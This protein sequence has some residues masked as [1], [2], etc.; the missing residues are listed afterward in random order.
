MSEIVKTGI[1]IVRSQGHF[2]IGK[3]PADVHL[4]GY[5]EFPGGKCE[6]NETPADCAT[7]E[8]QEETGISV[9][10][11]RLLLETQHTY[12]EKTVRLNFFLCAPV[13]PGLPSA[14]GN[15][16]WIPGNQLSQ[17]NFPDGNADVLNLLLQLPT[18]NTNP[19]PP[20]V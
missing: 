20:S 19:L 10:A 1:A 6:P 15:F 18:E 7:R 4:G 17:M 13:I 5:H 2:L 11:D 8:C 3:R 9:Q 16:T 12:P 14:T